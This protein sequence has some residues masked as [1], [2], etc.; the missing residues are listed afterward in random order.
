[1]K[2]SDWNV[3]AGIRFN[4]QAILSFSDG[5]LVRNLSTT[6]YFRK[7]IVKENNIYDRQKKINFVTSHANYVSTYE[8]I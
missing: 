4:K 1:M 7:Y 3:N 8:L 6:K 5:E 2:G